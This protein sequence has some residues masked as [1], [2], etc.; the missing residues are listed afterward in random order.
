ML[1]MA[2]FANNNFNQSLI[3]MSWFYANYGYQPRTNWPTEIHFY[4]Q[5]LA[6]HGQLMT[7]IHKT[8]MIH[9]EA[10]PESMAQYYN[11]MRRSIDMFKKGELVMLNGKNIWPNGRRWK[12]EDNVYRPLKIWSVGHNYRYCNFEISTW[13]KIHP[14]FNITL[15]ERFQGNNAEK[16]VVEINTDNTDQW[17][18]KKIAS[19]PSNDAA[20]K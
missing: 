17:M 6:I 11:I 4:N 8:I 14:T 13:G 2:E 19:G 1:A 5:D 12:L 9:L 16:E 7:S 18:D 10:V 3:R 15:L 20:T